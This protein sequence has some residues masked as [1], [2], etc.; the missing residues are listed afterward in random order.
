L[1]TWA[2]RLHIP[3]PASHTPLEHA[4]AFNSAVPEAG[5]T[6]DHLATLFV[7]QQYGRQEPSAQMLVDVADN[8]QT[9]RPKLWR[10][11]LGGQRFGRGSDAPAAEAPPAPQ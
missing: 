4:A 2:G 10:R 3:W 5:P 7:A 6:V 8:W 1:G 9:L 11:W